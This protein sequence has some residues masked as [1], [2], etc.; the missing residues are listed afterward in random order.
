MLILTQHA[1]EGHWKDDAS[2]QARHDRDA[3]RVQQHVNLV[4][5]LQL[6]AAVVEEPVWVVVVF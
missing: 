6:V 3:N 2:D 1:R 4:M 5:R